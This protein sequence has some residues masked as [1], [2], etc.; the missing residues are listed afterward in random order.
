MTVDIMADVLADTDSR[1]ASLEQAMQ[2]LILK[3]QQP[4]VEAAILADLDLPDQV[5]SL[6]Q[7]DRATQWTTDSA[8]AC[9]S[10]AWDI[11][12]HKA[13]LL[14]AASRCRL[15]PRSLEEMV[16]QWREEQTEEGDLGTIAGDVLLT[17]NYEQRQAV[18]PEVL[19]A[20]CTLLAGG[21]KEGKSLLGYHLAACVATGKP[22]L[23]QF[24]VQQ[25][26]VLFLALEDGEQRGKARLELQRQQLGLPPQD[27]RGVDF[28]FWDCPRL[29][30]GFASY[31]ARWLAQRP[32]ARLIIVDIL[33]KIRPRGRGCQDLYEEGYQ[34]TA[35]LARLAQDNNIALLVLHHSTKNPH[36]DPRLMVSGP[37]S[38]LGG[39]DNAWL[40]KRPY[41]EEEAEL[42]ISGR[43]IPEQEWALRFSGGLWTWQGHLREQRLSKQR[44]EVLTVLEEHPGGLRPL[45]L[46][47]ALG[48][49]PSSCRSLLQ[50]MRQ[51]GEVILEEGVYRRPGVHTVHTVAPVADVVEPPP[52][53][54]DRADAVDGA[55]TTDS[56]DSADSGDTTDAVDMPDS[57]DSGDRS[58]RADT[59]DAM[60][61]PGWLADEE[62][63]FL[64]P[65]SY[66]TMPVVP[67]G[68]EEPTQLGSTPEHDP[69]AAQRSTPAQ[70]GS[71][72]VNDWFWPC[73]PTGV[74][75]SRVPWQ[76][77]EIETI[78]N[79]QVLVYGLTPSGKL[80][81]WP[82]TQCRQAP[83]PQ[84][85]T[86]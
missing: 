48:K 59:V 8:L 67:G 2:D 24:P 12:R 64:S 14:A 38:L 75:T 25:G 86:P 15:S 10:E 82:L 49:N 5:L 76:A 62:D 83:P 16:Q 66:Q 21:A 44:Q 84:E 69:P 3:L 33:E 22:F 36:A 78:P 60:D 19:P 6:L 9:L 71:L 42:V 46:A 55:D 58:D 13:L 1:L 39:A 7:A 57:L 47:Q 51:D 73:L 29:G 52:E 65:E 41:G 80:N 63:P 27:F 26:Q 72:Q 18:I 40:L 53:E 70:T 28:K 79:G 77:V 74:S 32:Q 34:A 11:P 81:R 17:T 37:M 30:A 20:G 54:E 4:A 56:L 68:E 85:N 50:K 35:P 45:E 31:C 43:D 23:Q 61:A